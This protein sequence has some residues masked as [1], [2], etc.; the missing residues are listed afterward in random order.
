MQLVANIDNGM[1]MVAEFIFICVKV[2]TLSSHFMLF[3]VLTVQVKN[4]EYNS[5]M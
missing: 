3:D 1:L 4:V 5:K 2:N